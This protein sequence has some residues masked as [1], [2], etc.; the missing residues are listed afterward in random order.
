VL[1]TGGLARSCGALA[2]ETFG[3]HVQVQRI[4]RAGLAALRETIT[5]LATAEGLHAHR[6]AVDIRFDE[7]EMA[8]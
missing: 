4:D 1:P 5:T 8:R 6:A 7:R 2:V 3:K